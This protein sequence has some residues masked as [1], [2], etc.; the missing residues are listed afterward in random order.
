MTNF[1]IHPDMAE[2]LAAKKNVP[3]FSDPAEARAAWNAYGKAMQRP[4]PAGMI[5][6]DTVFP[7]PEGE[8]RP[9]PVR[10]YRPAQ[11]E[12]GGPCVFY[13][14]G[15]AF[16]KGSL[17]SGDVVAW[18]VA[19]QVGCTVVS[20]DY[21]LAP[22]FPY[23]AGLNDCYAALCHAAE[24]ASELGVDG[25]RIGVWG[26]S[27][28]GNLAAALC[29]MTRD[30]K[31]PR[32]SAQALNYP[33]LTDELTAESYRRYAESPGLRTAHM[34][35]CWNL[36]L[37]GERPTQHDCAAPLKAH[38]LTHLPPAHIHIAE[39]DC[40][41]DDGRAYARRLRDAGCEVEFRCAERMIHGFLRARFS[42]SDAA[43]EFSAP[44]FYLRQHLGLATIP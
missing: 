12:S 38:D 23:P 6:R 20:V 11:A 31:G 3:Q 28:G 25:S 4:Y 21:R 37:R 7:A 29:L 13:L 35:N 36:Y 17:E 32:I 16:I 34:D 42:G 27:A 1:D 39:L 43:G 44:C 41:A 10:I 14:H 18:G 33:C 22:D 5:V 26:D 24:H 9:I 30:R 40:L 8:A 19:D 2:L 15:G